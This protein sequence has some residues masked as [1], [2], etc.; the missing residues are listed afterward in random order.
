ME[1]LFKSEI[2]RFKTYY[3]KFQDMIALRFPLM[4][5]NLNF[6]EVCYE[7]IIVE[8]ICIDEKLMELQFKS[9]SLSM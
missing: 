2:N 7:T 3:Y 9:V 6:S 1:Q 5:K 8:E 4:L